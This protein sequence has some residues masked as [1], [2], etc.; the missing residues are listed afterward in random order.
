MYW[1]YIPNYL[2]CTQFKSNYSKSLFHHYKSENDKKFLSYNRLN[3]LKE[4]WVSYLL[5]NNI[6]S[7][8]YT[9]VHMHCLAYLRFFIILWDHEERDEWYKN[10]VNNNNWNLKSE[11]TRIKSVTKLY[12]TGWIMRVF[13]DLWMTKNVV[14][15][16]F[17]NHLKNQTKTYQPTNKSSYSL[18]AT[19][20][21]QAFTVSGR[22]KVDI[23]SNNL[24]KRLIQAI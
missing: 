15:V 21:F 23:N 13:K 7:C 16:Y 14:F 22:W 18:F 20:D 2:V 24:I 1:I 5:I 12:K 6:F 9:F 3:P 4:V 11:T 17:L 8:V 19:L 10:V